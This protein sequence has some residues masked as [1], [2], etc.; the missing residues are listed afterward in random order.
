M[1]IETKSA[2]EAPNER[3]CEMATITAKE[4]AV[5]CE[6]DPKSMRRFIRSQA[7]AGDGAII[8]ACGQGNRYNIDVEDA[9]RLVNA[10]KASNRSHATNVPARSASELQDLVFGDES[11]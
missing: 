6:T 1:A 7:K 10:F 9:K 4:L 5:L 2:K 8:D 3:E 11:A